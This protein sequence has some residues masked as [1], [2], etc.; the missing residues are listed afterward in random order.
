MEAAREMNQSMGEPY[1]DGELYQ[2][3]QLAYRFSQLSS[4]TAG[5]VLA[6]SFEKLLEAVK[7]AEA[8]HNGK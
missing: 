8:K 6:G 3:V 7:K 1:T 2:L 5:D 4:R